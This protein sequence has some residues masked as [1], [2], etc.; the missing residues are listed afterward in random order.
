ML[1]DNQKKAIETLDKPILI[2]GFAGTGKSFVFAK[3]IDYLIEKG[4]SKDKIIAI[5]NKNSIDAISKKFDNNFSPIPFHSFAYSLIEEFSNRI[6][7]LKKQIKIIEL[8]FQK[9][10][11]AEIINDLKIDLKNIKKDISFLAEEITITINDLK[12]DGIGLKEI[13]SVKIESQLPFSDFIKIYSK[14]EQFKLEKGLLDIAD[15]NY[16]LFNFLNEDSE[17]VSKLRLRFEYFL[18]DNF[19]DLNPLERKIIFLLSENNISVFEDINQKHFSISDEYLTENILLS[20]KKDYIKIILENDYRHT[21]NIF[22]SL[23]NIIGEDKK[24]LIVHSKE[25]GNIGK[26][27]FTNENFQKDY[28]KKKIREILRDNSSLGIICRR[29]E[30]VKK[31]KSIFCDLKIV[32]S[33]SNQFFDVNSGIIKNIFQILYFIDN[34]HSSN[35]YLFN[36]LL[37]EGIRE[38]TLKKISRKSSMMENSIYNVIKTKEKLSDL[39]EENRHIE[40]FLIRVEELINMNLIGKSIVEILKKV[41]LNF[42]FYRKAVI[43][44]DSNLIFEI[45]NFSSFTE[46]ILDLDKSIDMKRF[47]G[48]LNILKDMN[49]KSNETY[50]YENSKI[51]LGNIENLKYQEFD[52][53]IL[54][55]FNESIFPITFENSF[56]QKTLDINKE[57]HIIYEKKLF[58]IAF[59]RAKKFIELSSLKFSENGLKKIKESNFIDLI[60]SSKI[61]F[62][63]NIYESSDSKSDSINEKIQNELIEKINNLILLGNYDLAKSK[64]DLLK[65]LFEKKNDLTSFISKHPETE[66]YKKRIKNQNAFAIS[67]EPEK[68]IYS[69]SQIQTY[70]L[71]PRKYMYQYVLKIPTINRHY[72]DFGTTLH[73][74]IEEISILI[75]QKDEKDLELIFSKALNLLSKKW[76]SKGYLS[77]EDEI[78]YYEKGVDSIRKY[79]A[80][81]FELRKENKRKIIEREKN[82]IIDLGGKKF[83]GFIDRI[84]KVENN[85]EIIDYKTSNSIEMESKLN[86]NVQLN[87]YA[88]AFKSIYGFWPSKIG[89]WYL[90][91]DKIIS[92]NYE[93]D[94]FDRI[95]KCILDTIEKIEK[96]KFKATPTSFGCKYCDYRDICE[97]SK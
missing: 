21:Q 45:K 66:S 40:N 14:Y 48:I 91:H 64:I 8:N 23:T 42:G 43:L 39:E 65:S 31:I 6:P 73:S 24:D 96:S 36:I 82:F 92:V 11:I 85:F 9:I 30:E 55:Y 49:L 2:N 34:P 33:D 27:T 93:E 87:M 53:V 88:F 90:V 38:E 16:I 77:E 51:V 72:F 37:R 86:S 4:Y 5:C 60:D 44:K 12:N 81:E 94:L 70:N 13:F 54:P 22:S 59:S 76:I 78:E 97:E 74:V 75:E 28:I 68:M 83:T 7:N 29:D 67:I 58:Y 1:D 32:E 25:K 15:I 50:Y 26:I 52:F 17:I 95:K 69:V 41:L 20:K 3:K 62:I 46:N 18:V 80:K 89:L 47:C 57:E 61:N 79:I 35:S 63:E 84:D 71:C 10:F 56:F 19:E